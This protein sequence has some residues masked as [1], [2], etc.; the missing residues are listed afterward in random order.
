MKEKIT[1]GEALEDLKR[2]QGY[3]IL[4]NEIIYPIYKDAIDILID[5]EDAESRLTLKVIDNI[6]A[7]VDDTI[8]LGEQLKAELK[9]KFN[10]E[11]PE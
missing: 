9:E 3:K 2:Q 11:H 6:L 8:K 1:R 4:I 5:R 7:K 10:L